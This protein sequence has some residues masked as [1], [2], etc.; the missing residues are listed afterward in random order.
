MDKRPEPDSPT[1]RGPSLVEKAA[2]R[3]RQP[4]APTAPVGG[5]DDLADRG[6]AVHSSADLI[7]RAMRAIPDAAP[8]PLAMPP[9]QPASAAPHPAAT[10]AA[11][12][13]ATGGHR[14][15]SRAIAIDL[16][17][18]TAAGFITPD[19][20]RTPVSEEFR[21]VKR[22]VLAT[23]REAATRHPNLI[24]VTSAQPG[25]GKTFVS[26]NLAMS[27]A[28]ERDYKVLL[29]DADLAKPSI[30]REFGFDAD[31]GLIDY[32]LDT[33]VDLAS[34]MVRTDIVGLTLLPSGRPH[35]LNTELLASKRMEAVVDE[36]AKRYPDRVIIFD[37]APLL[38]T[39][40]AATL[41][42]H[43]GQIV[44]V[45]RAEETSRAMIETSLDLIKTCPR[46]GLLLNRARPLVGSRYFGYQNYKERYA[47]GRGDVT[48]AAAE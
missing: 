17:K 14:A 3:L 28:L 32:L 23:C 33:S 5:G 30:P 43:M 39:S 19:N 1:G 15:R 18:L 26:I 2:S 48:A 37:S 16:P 13:A 9:G 29:V 4:T 25:E 21:M 38:V 46:I 36:L 42:R 20:V 10:P 8:P 34:V 27:I 31:R 44:Y 41:A 22:A 40:E 11:P 45:V 24:M 47:Y 35:E 12:M 6:P 7:A